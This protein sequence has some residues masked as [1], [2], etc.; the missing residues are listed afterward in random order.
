MAIAGFNEG[1]LCVPQLAGSET[2]DSE[3]DAVQSLVQLPSE[4]QKEHVW[5]RSVPV[6]AT[7]AAQL[8]VSQLAYPLGSSKK[9]KTRLVLRIVAPVRWG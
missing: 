1:R 8:L 6:L 4:G 3:H 9:A 2:H 5:P 7:Q